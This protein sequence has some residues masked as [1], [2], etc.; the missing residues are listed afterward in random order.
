MSR[1]QIPSLRMFRS[2]TI[3]GMCQATSSC[4]QL[5]Q[6]H[7]VAFSFPFQLPRAGSS[8]VAPQHSV[9][10]LWEG[11]PGLEACR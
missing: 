8:P 3:A 5:G 4:G 7:G 10:M 11:F 9:G 1:A 6:D 2:T